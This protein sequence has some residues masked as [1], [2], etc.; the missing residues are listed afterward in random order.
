MRKR[1]SSRRFPRKSAWLL[2]ALGLGAAPA[3]AQNGV[4]I[5][6]TAPSPNGLTIKGGGANSELL[7]FRNNTDAPKWHWNLLGGGL[8]LSET[9]VADYR[10]FLKPG[11]RVGISTNNPV[12]LLSN[13]SQNIIDARGYGINPGSLT[14]AFNDQ[15]YAA[16]FF[17]ANNGV[18]GPG[19]FGGLAVKIAAI[20]PAS[21]ALDVSQGAVVGTP[22]TSLLRVAATGLVGIQNYDAQQLLHLGNNAYAKPVF[23]RLST[24]NGAAQRVWDLG[25][26]VDPANAGD[27]TGEY[28]DFA[29]RDASAN[30][31]RLLVEWNSGNVGVGT[32]APGYRLDVAGD[33]N[34][35][36][37]LRLAGQPMLYGRGNNVYLG[38]LMYAATAPTGINNT[39]VGAN[40]GN[41]LTSGINNTV[42]GFA[43]GDAI[44][45][46][47]SNALMGV[48]AGGSLTTGTDNVFIG[49]DPGLGSTVGGNNVGIGTQ[50]L[51]NSNGSENVG[52]GT[53]AGTSA[54]TGSYNTFVGSAA[55]LTNGAT[56]RS[57]ATAL[58][59]N[60]RVDK[61]DAVV[62][63]DPFNTAVAVG[64][65]TDAPSA[66]LDVAG[67]TSTVR[68]RGLTGSNTR[69]VTVAANGTLGTQAV[70]D[71]TN[72]IQNQTAADQTGGFRV[73]GN[74][75]VGGRLGVGTTAPFS[76]L[77]NTSQNIVGSD[78]Q[79]GNPGS[80]AWAANQAGFVAMVHNAGTGSFRNGLAVSVAGTDA[81]ASAL[82]VS[83]G[84]AQTVAGTTL[85]SVR[86]NGRVGVGTN[87][88]DAK[89][90]VE[91]GAGNLALKVTS[92]TA[93]YSTASATVSASNSTLNPTAMVHY[94]TT[95]S[96]NAANGTVTLGTGT[97]GQGLLLGN[98]DAQNLS[99]TYAT[100]TA[101]V[102]ANTIAH[103]V[104]LSS[105]W[106]LL[107]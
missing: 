2:A 74:G 86:A 11:G 27:A 92:G 38:S 22:G 80:L 53:N 68:L 106:R 107:Q 60:A 52:L 63:G 94:Y 85:L 37:L 47:Q 26:P 49:H 90:D 5:N 79:G 36:G 29:L 103:F 84:A 15:G 31:T 83:S 57:R 4:G 82:D 89:L 104:Y 97:E 1:Y 61:D 18:G 42:V 105:G 45:S 34:G 9:D 88:P 28:Y 81:D 20:D 39:F 8:N 23:L 59:Y 58:G 101:T 21:A 35:S 96:S 54:T 62:L 19:G 75:Y 50:A 46:G 102:N 43:A 40:V 76:Q 56:Q 70:P 25:V 64:I 10:L 48:Q 13:T 67:T 3:F 98:F 87:T 12:S 44:T 66:T 91:A 100:G 93:V 7:F 73:G 65:G 24:G 30:A 14:W 69:L 72:F 6:T 17:N 78:L 95:N 32:S 51:Y 77:A 16:S 99:V 33:I 55:N 41:Q 71:G